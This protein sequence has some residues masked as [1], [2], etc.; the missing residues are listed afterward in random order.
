METLAALRVRSQT[1]KENVGRQVFGMSDV[2]VSAREEPGGCCVCQGPML[3]QKIY[4]HSGRTLAHGSFKVS[5]TVWKCAAGCRY[6]SGERVTQ[7]ADCVRSRI[8]PQSVIGYD[9]MAE[10]GLK[11]F[12]HYRQRDEIRSE[13]KE[14]HGI[15][16]STG[17]ISALAVRF[18]E[19]LKVLHRMRSP[20][21]REA[22]RADGGYPMHIDATGENGRGTLLVIWSGWRQWV[23]GSWKIP[24]ES[25]DFIR[26][27]LK[28]VMEN[29]G[30]PLTIMRDFGKAMIPAVA[31]L[32]AKSPQ[33]IRVL[34]C[35]QHF[36]AD[37]GKDLLKDFH[38]ELRDLFRSFK[39]R[40]GLRALSRDLGRKI[41]PEMA[42]ARE[43]V[44]DWQQNDEADY[45]LPKGRDGLAVVRAF[46]QWVLDYS[47]D[48]TYGTFPFDRPYLDFFDRC[49]KGRRA[50]DAFLHHPAESLQRRILERFCR[51]PDPIVADR[52]AHK[53][54]NTLRSISSLFDELRDVL[55]IRPVT[56]EGRRVL[57]GPPSSAIEGK[58]E[59]RDMERDLTKW[60]LSL[61][62]RRPERGPGT[63]MRKAI[64]VIL[65]HLDRHGTSL[66]G[67]VIHLPEEVGGGIR[68]ADRTNYRLENFFGD[69]KHG[70]RRRSGR[71]NLTQDLENLPAEAPLAFNLT[72]PDYVEILC[73]TLD[74]LPAAFAEVDAI[75]QKTEQTRQTV[76]GLNDK[77]DKAITETASL[78]TS[79]RNIIRTNA[80]NRRIERAAKSRAPRSKK[81]A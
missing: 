36:L 50:A 77:P 70:E 54:A 9:V 22:M 72:R 16:L 29:F 33:D 45:A 4:Q 11:R 79:D 2:V 8:R 53:V 1:L 58:V 73:G 14:Q 52:H 18:L 24:T 43:A 80:M 34:G 20:A 3:V 30:D 55:R 74:R 81:S 56:H 44:K 26:P 60:E 67:H 51:V 35:H 59:L 39:V 27:T 21:L 64:D 76:P 23:L 31:D 32:V 6:P 15:V 75:R 12:V 40:P 62:E 17:E 69:E 65:D 5:E 19:Y 66:W 61:R 57:A 28:E 13:I 41:G 37:I 78:A 63:E 71:K 38:I 25:A 42:K 7:R 10:V 68:L 49:V 47:A 46:T 48:A